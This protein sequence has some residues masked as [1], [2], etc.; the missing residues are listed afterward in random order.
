MSIY[1]LLFIIA[2]SFVEIDVNH[3]LDLSQIIPD[4]NIREL[5]IKGVGY[6]IRY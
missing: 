2:L 4:I 6:I 1:L 3:G 5:F